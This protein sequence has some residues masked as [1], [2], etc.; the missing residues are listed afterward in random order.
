MGENVYNSTVIVGYSMNRIHEI[1]DK[2]VV[3]QIAGALEMCLADLKTRFNGSAEGILYM[4]SNARIGRE[5][6][7]EITR[8]EQ[9]Y[10]FTGIFGWR[11]KR[12]ETTSAIQL[13]D[14]AVLAGVRID[15]GATP[16][17]YDNDYRYN[18]GEYPG[19]NALGFSYDFEH[20][21]YTL[22]DYCAESLPISLP[23]MNSG[24][25]GS[26]K[27]G[28][29]N[30]GI[31]YPVTIKETPPPKPKP[32]PKPRPEK[33]YVYWPMIPTWFEECCYSCCCCVQTTCEE[34]IPGPCEPVRPACGPAGAEN[35]ES[36]EPTLAPSPDTPVS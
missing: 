32:D 21:G 28:D 7:S 17:R 24:A 9:N 1:T 26:I 10:N 19:D 5:Y 2:S 34:H 30:L 15:S 27:Y 8:P 29:V 35:G 4:D 23:G 22:G 18:L 11:L 14:G 12:N 6:L 25:A 33:P 3:N 36:Q 31:F 16:G 20:Y 13:A